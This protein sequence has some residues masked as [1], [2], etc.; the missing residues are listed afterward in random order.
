MPF[1]VPQSFSHDSIPIPESQAV[2]A[3]VMAL[4][5]CQRSQMLVKCLPLVSHFSVS[6][7]GG[8]VYFQPSPQPS[9]S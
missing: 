6:M 3:I 2:G 9:V 8:R 7:R 4:F 5:C 1:Q